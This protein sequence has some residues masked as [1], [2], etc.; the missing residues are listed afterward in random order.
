MLQLL[1]RLLKALNAE[2]SPAQ[3]AGAVALG[4]VAGWTPLW[5]PPNLLVFLLALVLRINL[6]TFILAWGLFTGLAY[7]FD[8]WFHALGLAMLTSEGLRGFWTVLYNT[9]L[10]RLSGLFN[11]VTLGSLLASLAAAAI[12]FPVTVL[13]VR[14]YRQHVLARV[15]RSRI[16]TLLRANR[17]YRLYAELRG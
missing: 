5:S 17:L 6:T 14:R 2:N 1:A 10:G 4:V 9:A 13:L 15:R 12:L 3:L 7:L 16:M 8:Q 11:T